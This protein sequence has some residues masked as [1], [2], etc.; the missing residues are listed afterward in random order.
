MTVDTDLFV[1]VGL[2]V[3]ALSIPSAVVAFAETRMP[4]VAL[5]IAGM[6][7]ATATA[8]VLGSPNGYSLSRIPHSFVEILARIIN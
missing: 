6:G 2:V 3:A 8:G 4:T 5:I 1:V 7:A